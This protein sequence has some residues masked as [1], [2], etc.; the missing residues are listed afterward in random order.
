MIRLQILG[1]YKNTNIHYSVFLCPL[2]KSIVIRQ[3]SNGIRQQHC[4]C[5]PKAYKHG[6]ACSKQK[7]SLYYV[8]SNMKARCYTHSS[9][10]Y[11]W[12]GAK[13]IKVCK[14]WHSYP[15]FKQWALSSGYQ[16]GL[17]LSRI[18]HV[19]HY[20]PSNCIWETK[21]ENCREAANRRWRNSNYS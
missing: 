6:D 2:C 10:Q 7:S 4:G 15:K 17:V 19:G 11:P 1:R 3:S 12:Y 21:N 20:N 18:N 16:N 9:S 14:I 5:R 8:W 13:H